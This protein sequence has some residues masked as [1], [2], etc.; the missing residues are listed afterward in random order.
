MMRKIR[1]AR[2]RTVVRSM[3]EKLYAQ[4]TLGLT[5]ALSKPHRR[6]RSSICPSILKELEKLKLTFMYP[7]WSVPSVS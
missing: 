1:V 7:E 4:L 2:T 6:I 5:R 3:L